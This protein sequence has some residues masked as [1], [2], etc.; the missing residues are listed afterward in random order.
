MINDQRRYIAVKPT[1]VPSK[2]AL[3]PMAPLKPAVFVRA[4][5]TTKPLLR[6]LTKRCE[7][8]HARKTTY[9]KLASLNPKSSSIFARSFKSAASSVIWSSD[10]GRSH[11]QRKNLFPCLRNA[12]QGCGITIQDRCQHLSNCPKTTHCVGTAQMEALSK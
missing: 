1:P 3:E 8:D 12:I 11:V 10:A 4:A 9:K 2:S 5:F 7:E 6:H